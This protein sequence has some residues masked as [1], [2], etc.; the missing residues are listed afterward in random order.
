M[1]NKIRDLILSVIMLVFGVAMIVLA[2]D[3][4][5]KSPAT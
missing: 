2:R 4:P 1:S 3:I 5:H